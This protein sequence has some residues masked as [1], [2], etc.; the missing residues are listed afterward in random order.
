M[1]SHEIRAVYMPYCIER[2]SDGQYVVLN[3]NYKPLGFRTSE[4]IDYGNYPIAAKLKGLTP[5][6]A[7]KISCTHSAD[8][9]KIY[10]YDDGCIPTD[11]AANMTQY[12][13]RLAVL[14]KLKIA[15][16]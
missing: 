16:D 2:Q 6:I 13:E 14:A 4:R 3:R 15:V 1:P 12:F 8:T 5:K 7:A 10:L 11:N 9:D